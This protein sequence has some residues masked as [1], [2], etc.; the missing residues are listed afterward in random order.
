MD[1][2]QLRYFTAV[3]TLGSF[4]RASAHLHVAQSAISRQ[5]QALEEEVGVSL[6]LRRK[7]RLQPTE[8][9]SLLM[10]RAAAIIEQVRTLRDDVREYAEVPKGVLRV[11]VVPF[12]SQLFMP[13]AVA[14][15]VREFT[16]VHVQIKTAMSGVLL[17]WLRDDLIDIAAMHS[18]WSG[19]EFACEP[20]A[21]SRMVVVLPPAR[22][23]GR[24]GFE[25]KDRYTLRE[26]AAMPLIL[27]TA[28]N[29]QRVLLEGAAL[30][31][32]LAL[33][34]VLEADNLGTILSLVEEG[35]GCTVIAYGA[36]HKLL[37]SG[38]VRMAT[39]DETIRTDIC[40]VTDGKRP[41]TAAMRRFRGCVR[42]EV[43][44][45]NERGDLP[46]QFFQLAPQRAG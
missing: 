37:G 5:V 36:V 26:L 17:G 14:T 2:R 33:N 40:L 43:E 22:P 3:V 28:D 30:S 42:A 45:V 38:T 19:M 10:E 39:L 4:S 23:A 35:V 25:V 32:G 8:A 6:I 20:L 44:A 15:F 21:H 11:G 1:L 34:V 13:R 7:P 27:T 29:P 31:H 18:P 12:T 41:V 16:E 24:I 46:A 9:G